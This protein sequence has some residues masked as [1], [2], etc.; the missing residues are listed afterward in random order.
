[1][2][3]DVVI[4]YEIADTFKLDP[5]KVKKWTAFEI[6]EAVTYLNEKAA[7]QKLKAEIDKA[8]GR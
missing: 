8:M 5:Q 1:V 7:G 4:I 3:P 2:L 6:N